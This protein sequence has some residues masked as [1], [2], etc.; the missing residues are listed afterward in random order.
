VKLQLSPEKLLRILALFCL[1]AMGLSMIY[2]VSH[3]GSR[4]ATFGRVHDLTSYF[5]T[6]LLF[7]V[8]FYAQYRLAPRFTKRNFSDRIGYSQSL[9]SLA[10]LLAGA[11]DTLIARPAADFSSGILYGMALLGEVVFIWNVIWSYTHSG[12]VASVAAKVPDRIG[13]ASVKDFGWPRTPEKL[14]GIGAAFFAAGGIISIAFNW[15]AYKFPVPWPGQVHFLSCGYLWLAAAAPFAI[16]AVLY[17]FL[18][19]SYNLIFEESL[20]RIH[21]VVTIIAVFDMVRVFMAREQ[22]IVSKLAELFFGPQFEWLG[23]LLGFSAVVFAINAYRGF[24]RN[25][26][27]P[28]RA[29]RWGVGI[30]VMVIAG[31]LAWR[32]LPAK[33]SAV[34]QSA[35]I[36]KKWE[37]TPVGSVAVALALGDDGTV[38]AASEDGFVYALDA[39]GALLWN[40]ASGRVRVSPTLGADGTIYVSAEDQ[41]VIAINRAG[42]QQ[43]ESG[44]GLP[45]ARRQIEGWL[46]TATAAIDQN[47]LYAPWRGLIHAIRMDNGRI[48]WEGRDSFQ[49]GGAVSI[50]PNGFIVYAGNGRI[51]AVSPEGYFAW[52]YPGRDPR[53][54]ANMT[55]KPGVGIPSG[56]FWLT[57]GIAV[58][59]DGTLFTCANDSRLLALAS[60][61]T[62]KWEF[63][64]ATSSVNWA[65]PLIAADE[66]IYFGSGDGNLYALNQ[67]GTQKWTLATG[68]TIVATPMLA[69]DGTIYVLNGVWLLAVSPEGKVLAKAMVAVGGNVQSSPTLAPDGTVYVASL[70]GKIM[71]FAGTHGGLMNSPWPKFQGGLANSGRARTF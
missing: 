5:F 69:E 44:P 16:F 59:D 14:F 19:D 28:G 1:V 48:G 71:A 36:P 21:F 49:Q 65:T 34:E 60:D 68:G 46:H 40:F 57:S 4:S 50:L 70:E 30:I 32:E 31:A 62:Y 61:G 11:L 58:G 37:F 12:E 15:P 55:A 9:G 10:L 3:V 20:T 67:D 25:K 6:A 43:W 53:L 18:I 2:V 51:D 29:F 52:Q 47:Y 17:K 45:P 33:R 24:R 63:K 7:F 26:V 41:R 54:S 8:F 27:R 13:D 66:T 56:P 64:S 39:S 22:A 35:S 23:V 42:T 38:Y